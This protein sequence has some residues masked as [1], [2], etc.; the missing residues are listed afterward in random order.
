MNSKNTATHK[1]TYSN[2]G[3]AKFIAAYYGKSGGIIL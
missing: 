1:I 3:I 2:I